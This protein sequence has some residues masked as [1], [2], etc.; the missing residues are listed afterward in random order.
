MKTYAQQ[1]KSRIRSLRQPCIRAPIS[2]IHLSLSLE[3]SPKEEVVGVA[4][5]FWSIYDWGEPCLDVLDLLHL[6]NTHYFMVAVYD[7]TL[8]VCS[9]MTL[10]ISIL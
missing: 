8:Q 6:L 2:I 3:I 5:L 9:V 7:G 4:V 1:N 10:S